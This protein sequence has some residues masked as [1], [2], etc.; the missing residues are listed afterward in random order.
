MKPNPP[1]Y[2]VVLETRTEH[3]ADVYSTEEEA[4]LRARHLV[5]EIRL[6]IAW[7]LHV[8]L[9]E[10]T[11]AK[12]YPEEE[13]GVLEVYDYHPK[14]AKARYS[15]RRTLASWFLH[16]QTLQDPEGEWARVAVYE[17]EH[18]PT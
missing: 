7:A 4:L 17:V 10:V 12:E 15:I 14:F 1:A 11:E 5:D 13:G 8:S 18:A 6:Q 3:R 9:D 16:G 2:A